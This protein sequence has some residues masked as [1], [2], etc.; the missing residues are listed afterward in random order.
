VGVATPEISIGSLSR[1]LGILAAAMSRWDDAARHF[2][3]AIAMN[4]RIGARPWLALAREGYAGALLGRGG[5][6]DEREAQEARAEAVE[7]YRKLGMAR[8]AERLRAAAALR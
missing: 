7:S 8:H 5:P 4:E 1:C 3:D 6:G 2:E